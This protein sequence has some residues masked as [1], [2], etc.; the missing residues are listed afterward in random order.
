MQEMN[1]IT[2]VP[3]APERPDGGHKGTFG[4]VVVVGGSATMLGAPALCATA[5]LRTGAGLVKLAVPGDLMLPTLGVQPSATGMTREQLDALEPKEGTVLAVGPG[6]GGADDV[7]E[8]VKSLI[9]GGHPMVLDADGLNALVELRRSH[10]DVPEVVR[11]ESP[12]VLTPHP[13][14]FR[15]LGE[16]FGIDGDPTDPEQRAGAAALL[17]DAT[18]A[19]VVLKGNHTV[20]TD[21]DRAY[22]NTTGNPALSTGG[23]GDVLTG[24]IASLWAQGMEPFD[25]A[26]LGVFLHG[27]AADA[28]AKEHGPAGLLAMEL[29][30][31][32]PDALNCKRR[33]DV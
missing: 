21:G 28:W 20:V 10:P 31:A 24:I 1:W 18:G 23:T 29:A 33:R 15:R 5:A 26:C 19:V 3:P 25:A 27:D 22:R 9:D 6:L 12:W 14:E 8:L 2:A 11:R 7:A 32:L 16:A 13:G 4:T 30:N 17:A